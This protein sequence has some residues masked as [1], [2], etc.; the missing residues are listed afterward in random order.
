MAWLALKKPVSWL[1]KTCQLSKLVPCYVNHPY[2]FLNINFKGEEN[3]KKAVFIVSTV[4]VNLVQDILKDI[5]KN[6][7]FEYCTVITNA[8]QAVHK[9]AKVLLDYDI[10][11][12]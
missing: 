7:K 6:S 10:K 11:V 4:V 3:Q 8:S 1:S 2:E 9:A 12:D 5:I